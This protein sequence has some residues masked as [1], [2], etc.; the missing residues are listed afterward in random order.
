MDGSRIDAIARSL[1]GATSRRTILGGL[2]ALGATA[3]RLP[4]AATARKRKNKQKPL[5][6]AYGCLDIGQKC[7]GSSA[8]CCSGICQG[9]KPKK[10]K[11]DKSVCAAHNAL[12]CTAGQDSCLGTNLYCG[13]AGICLQTTGKASYCG[14]TPSCAACQRDADCEAMKGPGAA[15]VVCAISSCPGTGGMACYAAAV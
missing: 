2:T 4:G 10:G 8:R 5:P 1:G 12:T 7:G 15:C 6:N 13:N 11:R 9:K 3:L 14:Q